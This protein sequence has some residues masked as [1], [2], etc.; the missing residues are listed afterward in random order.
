MRLFRLDLVGHGLH[1]PAS[2]PPIVRAAAQA[3]A[4]RAKENTEWRDR[5]SLVIGTRGSPLAL[6]QAHET[7]D[8]LAAR[9]A[10]AAERLPLERRSRRP[11]TRSRTAPL[12][13]A[14]G[15]GLFTKELDIALARRRDRSRRPF[16]QGSADRSAGRHRHRRLSAAR[17]RARRLHQPRGR[18]ILPICR[19]GAVVGSASLRRQAQ[20][21]RLRP[22]LRVTLLRGNVGTRLEEARTR[23]SRR[24]APR[25]GR[26]AAPR[27]HRAC[28]RDSRHRRLPAGRRAGRHRDRHPG[29]DARVASALAPILDAATGPA[30]AAERAFLAVLD[31]S[32]RTPIAGHARLDGAE[33]AL[34]GLVL[35]PDGSDSRASLGAAGRRSGRAGTRGGLD[36]RGPHAG[37]FPEARR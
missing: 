5:S 33:I 35:R 19:D 28:H 6:A 29:G 23:R 10:G 4:D 24:D 31:G 1:A 34:R 27:A 7:Q 13:E 9:S 16:G 12:S 17:G 18:G 30:L 36:L 3:N 32:C 8:R 21:R 11:A 37:R 26:P 20:V 25:D 22:D 14:G 2:P 15:K